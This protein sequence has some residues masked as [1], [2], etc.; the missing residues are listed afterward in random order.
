MPMLKKTSNYFW[1]N[2]LIKFCSFQNFPLTNFI[3]LDDNVFVYAIEQSFLL[4]IIIGRW[5]LPK[6][7]MSRDKL[8]NLLLV[9]IGKACDI[10]DFFTLFSHK[11]VALD[12]TFTYVVL[13]VWSLSVFQFPISFTE[14][15]EDN[16]IIRFHRDR[17]YMKVVVRT[18]NVCLK[19]EIWSILGAIFMQE[20]PFLVCRSYAVGALGIVD[21][22]I[23]FFLFKNSLII[24]MYLYRL[25]SLCLEMDPYSDLRTA[26]VETEIKN[27]GK[28]L[29]IQEIN[30]KEE[31]VT[32]NLFLNK[33]SE[34][35][36]NETQNKRLE[37]IT[38]THHTMNLENVDKQEK[39][40]PEKTADTNSAKSEK[41]HQET[42]YDH[43]IRNL[44][45]VDKQKNPIYVQKL[46]QIQTQQKFRR[47]S[48]KPNLNIAI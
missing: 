1:L 26:V 25:I 37:E 15:R 17:Q 41:S 8:S 39:V 33:H 13:V 18:L 4:V 20:F 36:P 19:T 30:N 29:T 32:H 14:A 45:N 31:T 46:L 40:C 35:F 7:Q 12:R 28:S 2:C 21:D 3:Q 43:H 27:G 34:A 22:T 47:I 6:G 42:K 23:I 10:T 48:K 24:A 44:N 38:N 9:M 11:N 5:I 16:V